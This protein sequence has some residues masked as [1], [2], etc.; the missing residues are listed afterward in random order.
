MSCT[1]ECLSMCVFF[2]SSSVAQINSTI[3]VASLDLEV[4]LKLMSFNVSI[5][6]ASALKKARG[7][8]VLCC[9]WTEA[10]EARQG[11]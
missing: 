7:S 11:I 2:L 4:Y 5:S 9:Y 3:S 8:T 6:R 10:E 1:E